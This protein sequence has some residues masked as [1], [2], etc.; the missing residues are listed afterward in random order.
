MTVE[1]IFLYESYGAGLGFEQTTPGSAVKRITDCV[2][3]PS[4]Y[5]PG[6]SCSKLT[7]SLVNDSLKFT[8]SDTQK[9]LT[10]F[11]QKISEYCVLNPL[12]QLTK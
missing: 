9:L 11:Q 8:S 3:E 10:F 6:P 7:I 12:K 5:C 4:S 1:K 2:L